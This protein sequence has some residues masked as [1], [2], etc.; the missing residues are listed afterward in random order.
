[1]VLAVGTLA[2]LGAAEHVAFASVQRAL[3]EA[4]PDADLRRVTFDVDG[5]RCVD[6]AEIAAGQFAAVP[7]AVAFTAFA[8]DHRVTIEYDAG[9]T[10][11]GQLRRALEGPVWSAKSEEFRFGVFKVREILSEEAP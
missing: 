11:P 6:T 8:A 3:H 9:Q 2:G 1:M 4:G 7:G 5:V 10:D